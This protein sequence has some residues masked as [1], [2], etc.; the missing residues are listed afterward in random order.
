M[1][2][3][4]DYA[5]I[6]SY[7]QSMKTAATGISNISKSLGYYYYGSVRTEGEFAAAFGKM[8]ADVQKLASDMASFIAD[9]ATIAEGIASEVSTLDGEIQGLILEAHI[10]S[11]EG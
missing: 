1:E 10:T 8:R 6:S 5:S 2:T 11:E 7:A 3:K 9:Y 4:I